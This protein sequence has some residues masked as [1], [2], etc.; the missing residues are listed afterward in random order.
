[1]I[2]SFGDKATEQFANGAFVPAF[3]GFAV[4][5]SKRL[6][7][8]GAATG[9]A[10]LRALPSNRLEALHGDLR[11]LFSIRINAQW[12]IVFRWGD[13]DRGPSEVR[14]VDYH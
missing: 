1:M 12:R 10:D 11:G 9:L 4:Q 2:L 6:D 5:A 7:I 8:L 3:Q 14:I 13:G